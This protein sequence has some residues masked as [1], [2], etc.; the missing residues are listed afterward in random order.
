[1]NVTRNY[2]DGLFNF[3][4]SENVKF[5]NKK[6]D[7]LRMVLRSYAR[8]ISTEASAQTMIGDIIS[9]RNRSTMD[10]KTFD[11]YM[12][13]LNDLFIIEGIDAW[14][15]NLRSKT[16]VRTTSTRHFV[17]TSIACCSL[18]ITPDSLIKTSIL[19][20]CSSKIWL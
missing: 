18:G 15:P 20:G 1:M 16:V 10:S 13:A 9:S 4:N 17:D 19:S 8:N 6:P 12:D 14:N 7:I 5:R 2:Y 11:D 3:E